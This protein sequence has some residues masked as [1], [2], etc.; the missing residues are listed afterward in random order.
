MVNIEQPK[1]LITLMT[2]TCE[3]P[4]QKTEAHKLLLSILRSLFE[5][6]TIIVILL[7]LL[8]MIQRIY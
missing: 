5:I 7:L 2:P 4:E 1:W 3:A 8:F 6:T